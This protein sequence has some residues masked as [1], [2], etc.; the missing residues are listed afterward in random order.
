MKEENFLNGQVHNQWEK[1]GS[2]DNDE[3]NKQIQDS[4][5]KKKNN[6][7]ICIFRSVYC[8]LK[9]P[10][11]WAAALLLRFVEFFWW[12]NILVC[13]FYP[14]VHQQIQL[15]EHSPCNTKTRKNH[16]I[17]SIMSTKIIVKANLSKETPQKIYFWFFKIIFVIITLVDIIHWRIFMIIHYSF[18]WNRISVFVDRISSKISRIIS[19]F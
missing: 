12:I 2:N 18:M 16:H 6:R 8:R 15:N 7:S 17:H 10:S 1:T 3:R 14:H 13:W 19:D 4:P 11:E 5:K 9:N